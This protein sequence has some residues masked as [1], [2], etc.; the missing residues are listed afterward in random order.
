MQ[1][2]T[3]AYRL[4][5]N[6]ERELWLGY[7]DEHA[8]ADEAESEAVRLGAD[9]K[10]CREQPAAVLTPPVVEDSVSVVPWIVTAAVAAVSV[11]LVAGWVLRGNPGDIP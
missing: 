8:R 9:L 5:T 7:L 3:S 2:S 10:A 1:T 6:L 11:G 4:T